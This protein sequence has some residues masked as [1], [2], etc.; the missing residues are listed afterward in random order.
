MARAAASNRAIIRDERETVIF[1]LVS[2]LVRTTV[3][4]EPVRSPLQPA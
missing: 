4:L 1:L 3:L 2:P